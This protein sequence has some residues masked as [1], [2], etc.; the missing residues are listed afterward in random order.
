A[1]RFV[2][3]AAAARPDVASVSVI[4]STRKGREID[5]V[6]ITS[7]PPDASAEGL[8]LIAVDRRHSVI[9][10]GMTQPREGL[11]LIDY[12][13]THAD[14]PRVRALLDST[15]IF[16]V[17]IVNPDG[18]SKMETIEDREVWNSL[19]KNT[20]GTCS[21][22]DVISQGVHIGH[23]WGFMWDYNA[24][25]GSFWDPCDVSY[26]GAEP[27]S[28]PE[29]VALRD[30]ILREN[31]KA[32]VFFHSRSKNSTSR[33]IVPYMYHKSFLS[34][35]RDDKKNKLMNQADLLEYDKMTELMQNGRT[36]SQ[37]ALD[38]TKY[39]VGTAWETLSKTI[40]G[41]ALDWT[42]DQAGA[43]SFILQ[44]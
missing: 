1:R 24:T 17:P 38:T 30:L 7:M 16:V 11:Y 23:N 4:G 42:F 28:E 29:S 33:I 15:R 25:A 8:D 5:A 18:Y 12:L 2:L 13:V 9:L 40:S 21:E 27:F 22:G 20:A 6:L 43:F 34:S 39:E 44:I 36:H 14:E 37:I 19:V 3:A 26:R 32:A 41:S 31:P 10:T 35:H